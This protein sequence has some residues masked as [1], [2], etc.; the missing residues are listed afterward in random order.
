MRI[1][2]VKARVREN[3]LLSG[4]TQGPL[5]FFGRIRPPADGAAKDLPGRWSMPEG[6]ERP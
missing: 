4:L 3:R 2:S 6:G 5:A 1:E